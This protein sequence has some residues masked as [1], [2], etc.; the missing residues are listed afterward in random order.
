MSA[1][2][3]DDLHAA[4]DVIGQV[5]MILLRGAFNT[6]H[7]QMYVELVNAATGYCRPSCAWLEL[8]ADDRAE[9]DTDECGCPCEHPA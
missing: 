6:S 8:D 3:V 7:E 2:I 4:E 5:D 1:D 9:H